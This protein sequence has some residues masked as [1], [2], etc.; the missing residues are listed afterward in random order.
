MNY[1]SYKGRGKNKQT[2]HER[3][4]TYLPSESEWVSNVY[5]LEEET[6]QY[7]ADDVMGGAN[8]ISNAP[9]QALANRTVFLKDNLI[10]LAEVLSAVQEAL[11]PLLNTIKSLKVQEQAVTNWDHE[12]QLKLENTAEAQRLYESIS[13]KV[14]A[15]TLTCANGVVFSHPIIEITLETNRTVFIRTDGSSVLVPNIHEVLDP[16]EEE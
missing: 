12:A 10:R 6:D 11:S 13:G 1:G 15:I 8:G 16:M 9:T 5:C 14:P 3:P 4:M 7:S 2:G